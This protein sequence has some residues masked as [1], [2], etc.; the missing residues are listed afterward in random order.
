MARIRSTKPEFW[1]D[2]CLG[3][4]SLLARLTFLSLKDHA[5]DE[6]RGL[7][8]PEAVWAAAHKHQGSGVKASF[9]RALSELAACKLCKKPHVVFY[10][11]DG[12]RYYWLPMFKK[13]QKID[14]P[15]PSKLPPPPN[16][17]NPRDYSP[18]EQG[19]GIKDQGSG[20]RDA[21]A[22]P[23]LPVPAL[24]VTPEEERDLDRTVSAFAFCNTPGV[25][26]KQNAVRDL[27]RLGLSHEFIRA[28]AHKQ[29]QKPFYDII[30]SIEKGKATPDFKAS[31]TPR[32]CR[33]CSG[34]GQYQNPKAP[35]GVT[36]LIPCPQCNKPLNGQNSTQ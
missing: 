26:A 25:P 20:R 29:E 33:I 18:L 4:M 15:S 17:T 12:C 31:E 28:I 11:A 21:G 19:S 14:K 22:S 27:R 10:K 32:T 2:E 3:K 9:K 13:H 6:G 8:D 34:L 35:I 16:S 36:D 23:P 24:P 5:D 30:R 1:D 7:G